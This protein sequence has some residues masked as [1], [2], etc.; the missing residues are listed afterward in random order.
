MIAKRLLIIFLN[1]GWPYLANFAFFGEKKIGLAASGLVIILLLLG[2]NDIFFGSYYIENAF[3]VLLSVYFLLFIHSTFSLWGRSREMML[4]RSKVAVAF[5][6]YLVPFLASFSVSD[7]PDT[8]FV[9]F[10]GL[11]PTLTPGDVVA[12]ER[13]SHVRSGD[14]VRFFS[15]DGHKNLGF[16]VAVDVEYLGMV[17]EFPA[18]CDPISCYR[19]NSICPLS[20]SKVDRGDVVNIEKNNGALVVTNYNI[21]ALNFKSDHEVFSYLVS[22]DRLS[23]K[24]F[25]AAS[26]SSWLSKFAPVESF[27][28]LNCKGS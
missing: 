9:Y 11:Q 21:S 17:G 12:V 28:K 19:M 20:L 8:E 24:V 5:A 16:V 26:R 3:L 25:G 4:S 1:F 14:F 2:A 22:E 15:S 6:L 23:G 10:K 13:A 27:S 7:Y 18:Y